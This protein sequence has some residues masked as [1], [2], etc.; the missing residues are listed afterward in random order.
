[1]KHVTKY[2]FLLLALVVVL[3]ACQNKPENSDSSD[4][5]SKSSSNGK[6]KLVLY[7]AG[8]DNLVKD[9]VK[10]FEKE[11][12]K[13]VEVFQGTTG[14]V[15]GR[16]EAE[17]DN[18]KADVVQLASLPA[19]LDYK[20]KDLIEPYKVK[21]HNKLYK[22]WI[23]KDGYYYGFSGSALGMSYNTKNVKN[24]PKDDKDLTKSQFKD[25]IAIPD[26]SESGTALDL[27]SIKVNNEGNKAWDDYKALKNNGMK[28]AGANKPALESVIKGEN[29]VVYGGVDYMVYA[30]KAK[31]EPVDIAY[32]K[33]G[34]AISPRPAFILKS[35]SH[36]ELAKK[37]MDYVTS[38]KGQKQV[39]DHYLIP[40]DKSA[41]KKK[42]KA[43]RADIKEFKYDWEN[44]SDK[45]EEVLKQFTELMR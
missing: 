24:P 1:M 22:D 8:P 40:A 33:S 16:L 19:A 7:A 42:G 11:S 41:E 14:E 44:L 28:L 13:K 10:E 20:K 29:D 35:S 31:G 25:K 38:S 34:T 23:D 26:P 18:P 37:Y 4:D 45:S 43:K 9:M 39:D 21:N 12:G 6:G 5:K 3:A 17:K 27:L 36:K 30:A 2:L 32:P 15:L